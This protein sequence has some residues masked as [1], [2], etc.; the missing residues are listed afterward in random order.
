MTEL[1]YSQLQDLPR[2]SNNTKPS[3][4][5]IH[6][7]EAL[8]EKSCDLVSRR[9]LGERSKDISCEQVDGL[10]ENIPDLLEKLNTFALLEGTKVVIFKDTK[11]FET[12]GAQQ[13]LIKQLEQAWQAGQPVK[14]AK[15]LLSLCS[16]M[17]L[18]PSDLH[19]RT[20]SHPD[21]KALVQ[22]IGFDAIN[23]LMQVCDE[24]GWPAASADDHVAELQQAI[25]KGFPSGHSLII[26]AGSRVPKTI[27]LYKTVDKC[28]VVVDCN[29]PKGERRA[30]KSAQETVL[31]QTLQELIQG[32]GKRL[33]PGLFEK[34]CQLTGFD[35][36]VFAQN[37]QKLI[38]Y[39]GSRQDNAFADRNLLQALFFTESLLSSDFHPLQ[40]LAALANQLR[41]LLVAK[42]FA[43][44]D[45][46]AV[47]KAGIGFPQFQQTVMPAIQSYDESTAKQATDW[48]GFRDPEKIKNEASDLRLAP[49]PKN[50]YP[51][52]QTLLKSERYTRQD[53]INGLILLNEA[54]VRMKSSGQDAALIIKKA[55]ADICGSAIGGKQ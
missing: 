24:L 11:M 23:Q 54:D 37:V 9:L 46:G 16:R 41:K 44:S 8:V 55:I 36:R 2:D 26:T 18:N 3:V 20:A 43:E 29:V 51:V 28:G 5:L 48:Q 19:T 39:T 13:R 27:K 1:S 52:F 49:S 21:L 31:R 33:A 25:E 53:I 30:D 14:A 35:L 7:E 40:L 10:P 12:G 4:W 38:D 42:N 22:H 45:F 17:G 32:T 34:L 6:G 47:W 50:A 15:T